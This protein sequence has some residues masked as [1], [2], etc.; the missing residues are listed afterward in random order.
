MNG[1]NSGR[2]EIICCWIEKC[3][4]QFI[5]NDVPYGTTMIFLL[6]ESH[7]SIHTFVDENKITLDWFTCALASD[8]EKLKFI[9]RDYV[10][11]NIL[12]MWKQYSC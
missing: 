11:V 9:I 8:F 6:A 10:D 3:E 4:N 7:L 1:K 2:I 12:C 5:K